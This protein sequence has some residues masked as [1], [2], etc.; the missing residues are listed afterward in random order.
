MARTFLCTSPS[1]SRAVLERLGDEGLV[2]VTGPRPGP[3]RGRV[4]VAPLT[5]DDDARDI[6]R[7]ALDGIDV[8]VQVDAE[9]TLVARLQDDLRRL[10]PVEEVR[11]DSVGPVLDAETIALLRRLGS[12]DR[13]ADAA[14]SLHLSKRTADRRLAHARHVF[15]VGSTT[16]LLVAAGRAGLLAG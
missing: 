10:G 7:A 2:A 5:D 1:A 16:A 12:G 9:R 15:G 14:R 6:V 3:G 11:D 13:V 4:W 8:V